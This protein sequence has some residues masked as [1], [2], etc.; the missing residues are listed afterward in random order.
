MDSINAITTNTE[1]N[2][3]KGIYGST[4][5]LMAIITM[6][7]DHTAATIL[8]KTLVVRGLYNLDYSNYQAV[9][10]FMTDN[11][12]LYYGYSAMR[13]IGRFAFPI[14][15]FL[16]VEG[17]IHTSNKRKYAIRLALFALISEIPFDLALFGKMFYFE[18]Q[19]VFFT[20]F[21]GFLV[22]M[23]FQLISEK[24]RDKKWLPVLSVAGAIAVGCSFTYFFHGILQVIIDIINILNI[25]DS[26]QLQNVTIII[27]IIAV[28][29]S[30]IALLVYIIMCKKT[31]AQIASVRFADL[32]VLVVGMGVAEE[33]IT[34]YS[35][36]GILTIAVM[37]A[38]RK[39]HFRSMLGGCIVLTI[40]SFAEITAFFALI[41]AYLYNGQRGLKLKYVFYIFYPTHLFILYLICYF[42]NLV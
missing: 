18:H 27:I 9:Q 22:L 4:L 3:K 37:Y 40:M 28:I 8:E 41:P 16:L 30:V 7:I 35:G 31:T 21:I 13:M 25:E 17:F 33:L 2:R 1:N 34:D 36:F 23:G 42:L 14:F 32:A 5:K 39:N 12:L 29:Q 24:A 20:L 38:L 6:L 15:C 11:W 10:D 19:N 26:I